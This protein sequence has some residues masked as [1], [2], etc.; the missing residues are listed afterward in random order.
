MLSRSLWIGT[1]A[2][3]RVSVLPHVP[4]SFEYIL[5]IA[6]VIFSVWSL[7]SRRRLPFLATSVALLVF[8]L[9]DVLRAQPWVY[10]YALFFVLLSTYT[11]KKESAP[12]TTLRI[13]QILFAGIYAW[14]GLQKINATFFLTISPWFIK[15]LISVAPG[16]ADL[17]GLVGMGAPLVELAAGVLLLFKKTQKYASWVLIGIH[18]LI[19]F[20]LGPLGYN[21][22]SVVWPW[23]IVMALYLFIL[24][25]KPVV[26]QKVYA[27]WYCV[28]VIIL[29]WIAPLGSFFHVWPLYFS[30][31]L[32]SG[33]VPSAQ[34]LTRTKDNAYFTKSLTGWSY[35]N[36]NVPVIP[37]VWY[38]KKV[39][40][41]VCS[42]TSAP[43]TLLFEI[44][45]RSKP[46]SL[47]HSTRRFQCQN[48]Q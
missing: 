20:S 35:Q 7:V 8:C 3:P 47:E 13:F 25:R 30:G 28:A 43:Q 21:T 46:T 2:F 5:F 22:N 9:F 6:L 48:L 40:N 23:N 41:S 10:Y 16:L 26:V 45:D 37:S 17:F 4:V 11:I 19:L 38:F 24:F 1:H 31:A 33:D 29:F 42:Q 14:S 32:Y 44:Q 39:F 36:V 15:P 18:L 34:I 12:N 27:N